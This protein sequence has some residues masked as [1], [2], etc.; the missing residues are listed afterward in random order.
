MKLSFADDIV[1]L[2]VGCFLVDVAS[3]HIG[4]SLMI[5]RLDDL[6][7]GQRKVSEF[8]VSDLNDLAGNVGYTAVIFFA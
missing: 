8:P 1:L 6:I 4:Y 5:E 7:L 2:N 3:C